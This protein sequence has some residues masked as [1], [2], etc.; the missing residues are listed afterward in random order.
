ML[1]LIEKEVMDARQALLALDNVIGKMD[2][3][4]SLAVAADTFSLNIK[5]EVRDSEDLS[6]VKI[7]N[8]RNLLTEF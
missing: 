4:L 7:E 6:T 5:P 8:A 1:Q 2:A 3:Y